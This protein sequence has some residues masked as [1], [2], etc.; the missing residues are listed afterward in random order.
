MFKTTRFGPKSEGAFFKAIS[1]IQYNPT[2]HKVVVTSA[3][4]GE[5]IAIFSPK[6]WNTEDQYPHP[7]WE[8]GGCM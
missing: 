2:H 8:L 6:M 3:W 5:G 4:M 1:D 7:Q